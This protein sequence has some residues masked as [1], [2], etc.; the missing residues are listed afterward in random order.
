MKKVNIPT[1]PNKILDIPTFRNIYKDTSIEKTLP[2]CQKT[3][4]YEIQCKG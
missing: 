1:S 4:Y 3:H 2:N